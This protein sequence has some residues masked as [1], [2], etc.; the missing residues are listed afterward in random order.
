MH[1]IKQKTSPQDRSMLYTMLMIF[2]SICFISAVTCFEAPLIVKLTS[3]Y[4]ITDSDLGLLLALTTALMAL[5]GIPWGYWAD[6]YSRTRLLSLS[7]A[8]TTLSMFGSALCLNLHLSYSVY[9]AF[10]LLAGLGLAGAGPIAMSA[11]MDTVSAEKRA[12]AMGLIGVAYASGAAVGMFLGSICLRLGMSLG[13]AYFIGALPGILYSLW[14]LLAKEPRRGSQDE[15]LRETVG[16]G[17]A[18]YLHHI[19]LSDFKVLFSKPVN[20]Q[21]LIITFF[22]QFPLQ[23]ISVWLVTS[24]MRQHGLNE[25]NATTLMIVVGLGQ[26]VGY[27]LGGVLSDLAYSRRRTGRLRVMIAA[28]I[29]GMIFFLTGFLSPFHL[30]LYVPLLLVTNVFIAALSPPASAM[31]LEVNLPEH[32]G[33]FSS[34][35][36]LVTNGARAAAWWLPPLI[37]ASYRGNYNMAFVFTALVYFPLVALCAFMMPR[38]EPALDHVQAILAARAESMGKQGNA[39]I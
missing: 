13:F 3:F 21:M 26:P 30:I 18:E 16:S 23:V 37:A 5:A 35:G 8:I 6:K 28:G 1:D 33:T 32:R 27:V 11:V 17:Q 9:F 25:L 20:L 24:L 34:L 31:G 22:I 7:L 36:Y 14:P 38:I 10:K 39:P 15:A 19:T 4:R 29:L 2:F 12:A